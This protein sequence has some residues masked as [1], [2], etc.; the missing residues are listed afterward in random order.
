MST[1]FG[2]RPEFC[3]QNQLSASSNS[4]APISQSSASRNVKAMPSTDHG[5]SFVSQFHDELRSSRNANPGLVGELTKLAKYSRLLEPKARSHGDNDTQQASCIVRAV[6]PCALPVGSW[7]RMK[8][9]ISQILKRKHE[10]K[11]LFDSVRNQGLACWVAAI[12]HPDQIGNTCWVEASRIKARSATQPTQG[13]ACW[14]KA[15]LPPS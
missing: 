10:T 14:V 1:K 15:V 8:N 11:R 12:C 9:I 3:W 7:P 6:F 13:H 2:Q 5:V 4:E